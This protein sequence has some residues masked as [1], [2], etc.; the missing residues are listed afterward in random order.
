MGNC[1]I[2]PLYCQEVS[3]RILREAGSHK[4]ARKREEVGRG[5]TRIGTDQGI[6][7]ETG[8]DELS[9]GNV[10]SLQH[11]CPFVFIR[12][13]FIKLFVSSRDRRAFIG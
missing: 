8:L 11:P 3:L 10:Q 13:L 2:C 9:V 7:R 1:I 5:W 6:K 4:K 12:G